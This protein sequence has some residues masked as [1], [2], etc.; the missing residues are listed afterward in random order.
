M[1]KHYPQVSDRSLIKLLG[2]TKTTIEAIRSKTH[3]KMTQIK[4]RHPVLLGLCS[5]KDFDALVQTTS[6]SALDS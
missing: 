5:Q 2:T 4:P 6:E 1:L 3:S